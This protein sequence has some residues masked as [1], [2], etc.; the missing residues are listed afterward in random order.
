[1]W[2]RLS[3]TYLSNA[4][5][6]VITFVVALVGA[7]SGTDWPANDLILLY[8]DPHAPEVTIGKF[9]V[10]IASLMSSVFFT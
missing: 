2:R 4:I 3:G 1:L 10:L 5:C 9:A 8:F 7:L 6:A